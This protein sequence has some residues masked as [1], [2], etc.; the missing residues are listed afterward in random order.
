MRM[1]NRPASNE[2]TMAAILIGALMIG[3][4]FA[5]I[6]RGPS[7]PAIP[8]PTVS[9][10]T[11]QPGVWDRMAP[12]CKVEGMIATECLE[13]FTLSEREAMRCENEDGNLDHQP[14]IWIDPHTGWLYY[15]VG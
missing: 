3:L 2:W 7:K 8:T 14:C 10:V 15:V 4:L 6:G 11:A 1:V 5:L 13:P 12:G 9:N